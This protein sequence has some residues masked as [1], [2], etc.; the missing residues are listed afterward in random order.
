MLQGFT[1][2]LDDIKWVLQWYYR[3]LKGAYQGYYRGVKVVYSG[4]T[5]IKHGF[6]SALQG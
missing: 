1:G 5:A 2:V 4:I 3:R 6:S